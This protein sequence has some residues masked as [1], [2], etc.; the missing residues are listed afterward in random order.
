MGKGLY[1][2][3]SI[4]KVKQKIIDLEINCSGSEIAAANEGEEENH[5]SNQYDAIAKSCVG[6][7]LCE[8]LFAKSK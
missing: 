2:I 5:T 3:T 1:L 4:K 8:Q 7:K 6:Q